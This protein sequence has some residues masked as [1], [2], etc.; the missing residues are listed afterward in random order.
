MVTEGN[1]NN[2]EMTV[3]KSAILPDNRYMHNKFKKKNQIHNM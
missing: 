1:R 3:N 2:L